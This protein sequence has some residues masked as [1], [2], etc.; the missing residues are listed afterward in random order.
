LNQ[1]PGT[2]LSTAKTEGSAFWPTRSDFGVLARQLTPYSPDGTVQITPTSVGIA[3]QAKG[4]LSVPVKIGDKVDPGN[5]GYKWFIETYP[6][7]RDEA[8]ADDPD[9][10]GSPLIDELHML[11]ID[12]DATLPV[13]VIWLLAVKILDSTVKGYHYE[14]QIPVFHCT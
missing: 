2:A 11:T 10:P 14:G 6:N 1:S 3:L 7:G 12:L 4:A 5:P 13:D 8:A 9:N